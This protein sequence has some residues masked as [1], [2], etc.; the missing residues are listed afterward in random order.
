MLEKSD[1]QYFEESLPFVRKFEASYEAGEKLPYFDEEEV[2]RIADYYFN[3]EIGSDEEIQEKILSVVEWGC[4]LHQDSERLIFMFLEICVE[5]GCYDRAL[6]M[7]NYL[8][9]KR[10]PLV[11]YY[12]YMIELAEGKRKTVTK[13]FVQAKDLFAKE[14]WM[15]LAN[16]YCTWL[17]QNENFEEAYCFLKQVVVKNKDEEQMLL[18]NMANCL[19][20]LRRDEEAGDYYNLILDQDPYA[21]DIWL[22]LARIQYMMAQYDNAIDS[23]RFALAIDPDNE[24]GMEILGNSYLEKENYEEAINIFENMLKR[25]NNEENALIFLANACL[26][27]NRRDRAVECYRRLYEI[28]PEDHE[29]QLLISMTMIDLGLYKEAV[30][31]LDNMLVETP[32]ALEVFPLKGDVL[33][34]MGLYD[35]AMRCINIG[36][37]CVESQQRETSI[38]EMLYM[39]KSKLLFFMKDNEGAIELLNV[40]FENGHANFGFSMMKNIYDDTIE[41]Y[42][43]ALREVYKL[44]PSLLENVNLES[45]VARHNL[46][47]GKREDFRV[48]IQNDLKDLYF[49]LKSFFYN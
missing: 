38:R 41:I 27:L 11:V 47:E 17:Y 4:M 30:N 42:I 8:S 24:T 45:F 34:K 6:N 15:L 39:L 18:Y 21:D 40:T 46:M 22:R 48:D 31:V 43:I 25:T 28:M 5:F 2:E 19:E 49:E 10:N 36:L 13:E 3:N 44:Y 1:Q 12:K 35:E 26:K 33:L 37:A 14:I 16:S 32:N 9:E 29:K 23:A 20:A 7:A